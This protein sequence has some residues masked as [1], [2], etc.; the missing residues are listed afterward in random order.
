MVELRIKPKTSLI[1][2]CPKGVQSVTCPETAPWGMLLLSLREGENYNVSLVAWHYETRPKLMTCLPGSPAHDRDFISLKKL[3]ST[4][5]WV[6]LQPFLTHCTNAVMWACLFFFFEDCCCSQ[7]CCLAS[8]TSSALLLRDS[9]I[10][11]CA[12]NSVRGRDQ[13]LRSLVCS[14]WNSSCLTAGAR[15]VV[16][17]SSSTF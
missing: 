17:V 1:Q 2:S 8:D 7:C 3:C 11:V 4:G 13:C 6:D 9:R 5:S 15:R 16:L 12:S 10:K 14:L